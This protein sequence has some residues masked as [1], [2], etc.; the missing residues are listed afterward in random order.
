MSVLLGLYNTYE[1]RPPPTIHTHTPPA[2]DARTLCTS[3]VWG[4][5]KENILVKLVRV[6][7]IHPAVGPTLAAN[8]H[9]VHNLLDTLREFQRF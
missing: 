8:K 7:F 2:R 4:R 1:G 6:L 9:L 5:E 3:P